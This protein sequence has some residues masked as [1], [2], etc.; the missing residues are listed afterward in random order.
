M[1]GFELRISG[2]GS[3]RCTNWATTT[4]PEVENHCESWKISVYAWTRIRDFRMCR[5]AC[6]PNATTWI[7]NLKKQISIDEWIWTWSIKSS[8]NNKP[9]RKKSWI[10]RGF[11]TFSSTP[12]R[13]AFQSKTKGSPR[14]PSA[15]S[16]NLKSW[17]EPNI[18]FVCKTGK[19]SN[20]NHPFE[21]C[22]LAQWSNLGFQVCCQ[23]FNSLHSCTEMFLMSN[24]LM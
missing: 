22:S 21:G 18:S 20:K 11:A 2:I 6:Y 23:G 12:L 24:P 3:D 17:Q 16:N 14:H 19:P 5:Q 9:M 7:L 8:V 1:S 15:S 13:D 10:E 4:A